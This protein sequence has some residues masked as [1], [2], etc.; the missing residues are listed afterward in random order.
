MS[1]SITCPHCGAPNVSGA[2]FCESCGKALPSAAA[3]GPR[4]VSADALPQTALGHQLVTGEL[5]K[6]QKNASTA[7][8]VV[9]I[10]ASAVAGIL[11][12]VAQSNPGASQALPPVVMAIQV[13]V[14][15]IFWGLWAWSRKAPLPATIVGLVVYATLVV[16]NVIAATSQMAQSNERRPANGIGGLGIGWLDIVVLVVLGKGIEAG[17]KHKRL[18]QSGGGGPAGNNP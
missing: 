11:I 2:Q 8:L 3:T 13:G 4:V 1:T 14:A 10:I 6:T 17:V 15:L 7:L 9:A 5:A 16:L 12:A 18:V